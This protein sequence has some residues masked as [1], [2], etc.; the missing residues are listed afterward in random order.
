MGKR[1]KQQRRGKGSPTYRANSHKFKEKA[2]YREIDEK[3]KE[4]V[5]GE[6]LSL[7]DDPSRTSI[8]MKVQYNDGKVNY[9]PAPEGVKV[10]EQIK[11]GYQADPKLHNIAPLEKIPEGYPVFNLESNPGDGGKIAKSSGTVAWIT[12][13]EENKV[14][15][16]LPSKTIKAFNPK[17]R[18]T[19]GK[20][21]GGGRKE[22]PIL[23]AGKKH[24]KKKA[25]GQKYPTVRG[26]KMSAADHPFG[27][28][29]H[30]NAVTKKGE[31]APPGQHVGSFG[32]SSTGRR[33]KEK[34]NG[35]GE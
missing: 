32:A 18:A 28:K 11:E 6:A 15:V 3:E 21:A 5:E 10:G 2:R 4:Q 19:I 33:G 16:R 17:C 24:Y 7:I 20:A 23:K 35:K 1:L 34:K 14:K 30:H 22:K 31:T 27:G 25:R 26:V 8:L 9:L 12:S 13:K 29:E